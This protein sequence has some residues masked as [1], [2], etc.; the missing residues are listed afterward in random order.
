MFATPQTDLSYVNLTW[1]RAT[2]P[3]AVGGPG[4]FTT[5]SAVCWIFGRSL[6]DA[7]GGRIPIGLA[8]VNWGGT[9]IQAWSSPDALEKC[10][11][12]PNRNA[13]GANGNSSLWNARMAPFTTGPTSFAGIHFYQG[14]SNAPPFPIFTPGA[15]ACALDALIADW[16]AKLGS[17]PTQWFGVVQLA[18]FTAPASWGYAKVR[19]EQLAA[20]RSANASV[21]SAID[22]GDALGP[23]GT[24]H[25]RF[26][27]PVGERLAAAAL[28]L[29]YGRAD[30]PAWLHPMASG[31]ADTTPAGGS[32]TVSA[33][34][35]FEAG[36]VQGGG[37][38]LNASANACPRDDLQGFPPFAYFSALCAGFSAVVGA[39]AG[40]PGLPTRF[41]RLN[42][43]ALLNGATLDA[44]TFTLPQAAAHCE[45]LAARGCVGFQVT[46]APPPRDNATAALFAFKSLADLHADENATAWA[47]FTPYGTYALPATAAVAADGLS[48]D[49]TADC[50][51]LCASGQ[52]VLRGVSYA[53]GSWPVANLF[54]GSGMPALPFFI[55]FNA[56]T[57]AGEPVKHF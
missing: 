20:L 10:L 6:F 30:G 39:P 26:K 19:A 44:G 24:Y 53:W 17:G 51:A 55:N 28:R 37:L 46:N 15:Y 18:P 27:R 56:S 4:N 9:V 40:R 8:S 52:A 41:T 21:S 23:W 14:E 32:G 50:G 3:G 5:F 36:S 49:I 1:T 43:T 7:L 48:L 57:G 31:G 11:P 54:A 13:P 38:A 16:R 45:A 2:T 33:R 35:A 42:G 34:V 22:V 29:R 25:P 12:N 47:T